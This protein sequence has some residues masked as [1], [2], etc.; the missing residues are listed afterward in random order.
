MDVQYIYRHSPL[1]HGLA[2]FYCVSQ[3]PTL[4]RHFNFPEMLV[5]NDNISKKLASKNPSFN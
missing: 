1:H 2:S 4:M 3:K 5:A